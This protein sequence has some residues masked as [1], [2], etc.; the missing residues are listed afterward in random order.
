MKLLQW[1]GV[2]RTIARRA[3]HTVNYGQNEIN[4][5]VLLVNRLS[6]YFFALAR[7]INYRKHCEDILYERGA[8]SFTIHKSRCGV[9]GKKIITIE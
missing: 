1:S 8:K 7:V 4:N 9:L 5:Q 3:E 6:D 2:A